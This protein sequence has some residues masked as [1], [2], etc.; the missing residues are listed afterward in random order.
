MMVSK[1]PEL[2]LHTTPIT[3]GMAVAL[4]APRL[5]LA[6]LLHFFLPDSRV[7]PH[8]GTTRPEL[9][10]DTGIELLIHRIISLGAQP[11]QLNAYLVG[12]ADLIQGQ[13]LEELALGRRNSD[14]AR[15][16]I[17]EADIRIVGTR[18]GGVQARR[19]AVEV[20]TG[21]VRITET[22]SRQGSK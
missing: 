16:T 22:P 9:F 17:E 5:G 2:V 12:G 14:V 15:R 3:S 10:G 18:V 20:D 19:V 7:D 21:L 8:R 11:D 1:N 13:D 6:G 4:S